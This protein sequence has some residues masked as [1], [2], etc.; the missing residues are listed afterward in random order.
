MVTDGQHC[1]AFTESGLFF[2]DSSISK[3]NPSGLQINSLVGSGGKFLAI[4]ALELNG[5]VGVFS[6]MDGGRSWKVSE[7]GLPSSGCKA[8]K[9]EDGLAICIS[10]SGAYLSED[11]GGAW[12][13]LENPLSFE[14]CLGLD[15][16]NGFSLNPMITTY[17]GHLFSFLGIR[18]SGFGESAKMQFVFKYS[19]D[20][21]KY[22]ITVASPTN[23]PQ[24]VHFECREIIPAPD[25]IYMLL[26][27]GSILSADKNNWGPME[28]FAF[29]TKFEW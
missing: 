19:D 4:G 26:R 9:A 15:A 20:Q 5:K 12:K 29:A 25:L 14:S 17:R 6:S 13:L 8:L 16:E 27:N 7:D 18:Q 3:W 23:I 22:W 28:G 21:G 1:A 10:D 2:S 11:M 24:P